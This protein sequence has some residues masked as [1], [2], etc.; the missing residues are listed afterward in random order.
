MLKYL[1]YAL[2][3]HGDV[4]P[5]IPGEHSRRFAAAIPNAR[6]VVYPDVGHLPQQEIPERSAKDV[7]R[8]LDRLAPGA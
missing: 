5:L 2:I 3:L 6:L 8:F 7:A 4:D 1:S